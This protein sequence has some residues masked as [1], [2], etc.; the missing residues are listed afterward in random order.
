MPIM[1]NPAWVVYEHAITPAGLSTEFQLFASVP[2]PMT[3][4]PNAAPLIVGTEFTVTL[5]AMFFLGYWIWCCPAGGQATT[6]QQFALWQVTGAATGTLVTGS[7]LTSD[8]LFTGGWNCVKFVNPLPLTQWAPYRAVTG[9]T[10]PYP[11]TLGDWS[12]GGQRSA[13]IVNGPLVGFSD[14]TG[15]FPDRFGSSQGTL[16]TGTS[17]PSAIYP[18]TGTSGSNQWLDVEVA[19]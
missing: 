13:G 8:P 14:I 3:A 6:G 17:D 10:G 11:S 15:S 19:Y 2:G 4:A 16:A 5:P 9:F 1:L 18:A 7:Q 12:I